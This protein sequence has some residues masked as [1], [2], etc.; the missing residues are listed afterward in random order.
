MVESSGTGGT[1]VV[2]NEKGNVMAPAKYDTEEERLRDLIG[3][4]YQIADQGL[5]SD[6]LD[7]ALKILLLDVLA[8][9]ESEA[10]QK[11]LED[12]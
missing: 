5:M 12:D 1:R 10:A 11:L 7:E 9:P 6:E 3:R 8:D 4:L 2:K